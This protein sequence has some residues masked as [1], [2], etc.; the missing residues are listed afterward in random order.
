MSRILKTLPNV[1]T[2][3]Y[4][5]RGNSMHNGIDIKG[6]KNGT[7]VTDYIIA[8][9]DGKVIAMQNNMKND[10]KSSGTA[11]YGNYVKIVHENGYST[12]YAH[13]DKGSI[14][15][16]V[17]DFVKQGHVI[18]FM[19]DT[20]NS[21]GDHLHF[22]VRLNNIR[23]NPT[24]YIDADLPRQT[25]KKEDITMADI[26]YTVVRGDTL[27]K[28]AV[29]YKTTYIKLAQYNNIKSPYIISVGQKIKIPTTTSTIAPTVPNPKPVKPIDYPITKDLGSGDYAIIGKPEKIV[30]ADLQCKSP[31]GWF[32]NCISG[33]FFNRA[34]S[35]VASILAVES[36][37]K[38]RE[39]NKWA[40]HQW[41]GFPESV[42]VAY[43]DGTFDTLRIKGLN[44]IKKP[45]LWAIGGMG[46]LDNYNPSSEGFKSGIVFQGQKFDFS[47]VL[48]KT[49]HTV[50]GIDKDGLVHLIYVKNKSG[51]DVN[52]LCKS[53]GLTNA[54]MLDGGSIASIHTDKYKQNIYT[55]M[56]NIIQL[57]K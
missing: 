28:I 32:T 19:G 2:S 57:A 4:G 49:G 13:M 20:G 8:H 14:T 27:S 24:P 15:V 52:K 39:I 29:K 54:V 33:T 37:G 1:I 47:D 9:T 18:G 5:K 22:E 16:K 50:I 6:F 43:K 56:S 30:I 17:G 46:L 41:C 51:S 55:K 40:C 3:P 45:Y 35:K 48:R 42:L 44:E 10:K 23:I 31:T 21:Y 34:T 11:S 26:I 53:L 12:L 25:K 38:L 36:Y 7:R